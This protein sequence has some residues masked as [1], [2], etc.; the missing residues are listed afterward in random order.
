MRKP[1]TVDEHSVLAT[2]FRRMN[3]A[4]ATVGTLLQGIDP[5]DYKANRYVSGIRTRLQAFVGHMDKALLREYPEYQYR[6]VYYD[7]PRTTL[8]WTPRKERHHEAQDQQA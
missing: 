2:E 3:Q 1:L 7:Q 4:L 6:L 5:K 8:K